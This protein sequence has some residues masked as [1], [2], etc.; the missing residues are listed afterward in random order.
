MSHISQLPPA[1]QIHIVCAL[2]A[3]GLGPFA[4][5][6]QHRDFWHKFMGYAWVAAMIGAAASSFFLSGF[7]ILGPFS[8]I[9][10]LSIFVFVQLWLG[11]CAARLANFRAHQRYMKGTYLHGTCLAFAA[12]FWPNRYMSDTFLGGHVVLSFAVMIA[13]AL[14]AGW[15]SWAPRSGVATLAARA[16]DDQ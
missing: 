7:A 5:W 15:L 1:L 14:V 8:P 12:S 3:L 11:V 4:I 2:V 13:I 9:H 16:R 10:L 6:R